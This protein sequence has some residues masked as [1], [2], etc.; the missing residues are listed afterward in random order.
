MT[1]RLK[2]TQKSI[3]QHRRRCLGA[4]ETCSVQKNDGTRKAGWGLACYISTHAGRLKGLN[5]ETRRHTPPR[6]APGLRGVAS[7][8]SSQAFVRMSSA[9]KSGRPRLRPCVSL[10]VCC[11]STVG[12][13]Q[14]HPALRVVPFSPPKEVSLHSLSAGPSSCRPRH[15][16]PGIAAEHRTTAWHV[17]HENL[18]AHAHSLLASPTEAALTASPGARPRSE[19]CCGA[20]RRLR[21]GGGR[22]AAERAAV[23]RPLAQAAGP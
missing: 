3:A 19:G 20:S 5:N 16:E 10:S 22:H 12:T 4:R 2:F 17:A 15:R 21:R 1:G 8:G 13:V 23:P 6:R 7:S 14:S 9:T 18:P 11:A